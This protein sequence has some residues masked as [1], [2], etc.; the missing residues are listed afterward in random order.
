MKFLH[1]NKKLSVSF[2]FIFLISIFYLNILNENYEYYFFNSK[3]NIL[4]KYLILILLFFI[5]FF[6]FYKEKQYKNKIFYLG[7][8]FLF[9]FL[10]NGIIG[11]IFFSKGILCLFISYLLYK[12]LND[13]YIYKVLEKISRFILLL[14]FS[15]Y[16]TAKILAINSE[17]F[18][19]DYAINHNKDL[20]IIVIFL[21]YLVIQKK[22]FK[23]SKLDFCLLTS[24]NLIFLYF[25][26]SK[27]LFCLLLILILLKTIN[28][29]YT[30]NIFIIS[31]ILIFTSSLFL[32]N[33]SNNYNKFEN[34]FL[35]LDQIT[36]LRI[37]R[38]LYPCEWSEYRY[39]KSR[40]YQDMINNDNAYKN[41]P[42]NKNDKVTLLPMH[43]LNYNFDYYLD[44]NLLKNSKKN[45]FFKLNNISRDYN[46]DN[47][48]A[49]Y[50]Y[51]NGLFF[52]VIFVI[53]VV[54]LLLF[55]SKN[56]KESELIIYIILGLTYFVLHTG[57]FA[58]GNLLALL[59]NA[60]LFQSFYSKQNV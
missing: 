20:A 59:L 15:I 54:K 22:N 44:K 24:C 57:L 52:F 19:F 12:C 32:V 35:S 11:I 13:I 4:L 58:P 42:Y 14:F 50:L 37:S 43:F 53:V 10:V 55:L 40:S 28:K 6:L 46:L 2:F 41:C 27:T 18:F 17:T 39:F 34:L 49:K 21:S 31:F 30:I 26:K 36:S 16:F 9:P 3:N 56:S 51:F 23:D 5:S 7:Y 45:Y 8:I 25:N 47:S 1:I 48:F 38:M 33:K 60:L 29:K